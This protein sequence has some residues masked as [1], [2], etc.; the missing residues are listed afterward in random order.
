MF[1]TRSDT[2]RFEQQRLI[3][4]RAQDIRSKGFEFSNVNSIKLEKML[5]AV[6]SFVDDTNLWE[7]RNI[8]VEMITIVL[9]ECLMLHEAI[10]GKTQSR[11]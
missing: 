3:L 1:G 5:L 10:G 7:N 2:F 9:H 6:S 4:L 11:K 8:G